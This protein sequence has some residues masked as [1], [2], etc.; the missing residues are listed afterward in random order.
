MSETWGK[1]AKNNTI[2][3]GQGACNNTV[4]WGQTQKDSSVAQSWSGDTDISG[5][6]GGSSDLT[7]RIY[8]IDVTKDPTQTEYPIRF[9]FYYNQTQ[10]SNENITID[11]GDGTIELVNV[12]N[13]NDQHIG[14]TY[15]DVNTSL[16]T[17]KVGKKDEASKIKK[18]GFYPYQKDAA[19]VSIKPGYMA[20]G[21]VQ[22]GD[23]LLD[24]FNGN[25]Y[26]PYCQWIET[27]YPK[28]L[29]GKPTSLLHSFYQNTENISYPSLPTLDVS[30]VTNF[31]SMF[32]ANRN[33]ITSGSVSG[34]IDVSSWDTSSVTTLSSIFMFVDKPSL[35]EIKVSKFNT[36]SVLLM[37]NMFYSVKASTID[38]ETKVIA[39]ADSPTGSSYTAWDVTS[40]T[41]FRSAFGYASNFNADLSTWNVSSNCLSI[42]NMFLYA[43]IFNRDISGWD[44]SNCG[45]GNYLTG[46]RGVFIG[47]TAFNQNLSSWVISADWNT[48]GTGSQNADMI[49]CFSNSGMNTENYTDTLVGWA[50]QV[51]KNQAPFNVNASSQIN[52]TFDNAR[53]S[54]NASGQTYLIKYGADWTNTGWANS[55]AALT[56]L[57]TATASEGAG[58]TY[59]D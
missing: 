10:N 21:F 22:W 59:S 34:V 58:W 25:S 42:Y 57:T 41:T 33:F 1:G 28:F 37:L 27:D 3:W 14:H 12:G 17:V 55:G 11:W 45:I 19:G 50:V 15:T 9:E 26:M 35:T 6:S 23:G 40:V 5:C 2:G 48:S 18:W 31:T 47:A 36:S 8:N 43:T 7:Q 4:G 39:A 51:Y 16:Y 32:Y 52:M 13:G 24:N 38:C 30:N 46:F 29:A 54:D 56:F 49:G 44:T 20:C 53:T